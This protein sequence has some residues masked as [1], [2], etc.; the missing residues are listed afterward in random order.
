MTVCA[1]ETQPVSVHPNTIKDSNKCL[2]RLQA[3]FRQQLRRLRSYLDRR[4]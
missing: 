3:I 1:Y 2:F 4:N